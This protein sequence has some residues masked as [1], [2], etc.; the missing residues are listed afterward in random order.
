MG[1]IIPTD[2]FYQADDYGTL[3]IE[4]TGGSRDKQGAEGT[5]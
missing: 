1:R 5:K 3:G 4:R 2:L